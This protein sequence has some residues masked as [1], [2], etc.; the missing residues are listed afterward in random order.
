MAVEQFYE[1]VLI[2]A[3]TNGG[4]RIIS[5]PAAAFPE[6]ERGRLS[7]PT[8]AVEAGPEPL[9]IPPIAVEFAQVFEEANF[10]GFF[11]AANL[12]QLVGA[13]L[14]ADSNDGRVPRETYV[15]WRWITQESR[16]ARA[17]SYIA[18]ER[19]IPLTASSIDLHSFAD[20]AASMG[21]AGVGAFVG[22]VVVG[23]SPLLFLA[24]PAGVILVMASRGAGRAVAAAAEYHLRNLLRVPEDWE[25]DEGP[26]TPRRP[27]R[28]S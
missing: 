27:R 5:V 22:L 2:D 17:A 3:E 21:G 9:V 14:V 7:T 12:D 25:P 8:L 15:D 1:T 10:V 6:E 13:V 20:I 24:V 23:S 28:R 16:F 18:T 11:S 4:V 26:I 19:V